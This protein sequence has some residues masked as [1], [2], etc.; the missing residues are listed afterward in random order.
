MMWPAETAGSVSYYDVAPL[1]NTIERLVD[2]DCI[3]SNRVRFSV[4]AVNVG[5]GNFTYFDNSMHNITPA[6][7]MASGALPPC[8]T[9]CVNS[10]AKSRCPARVPGAY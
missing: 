10:W 8:C 3:N 5:T 6:H 2:F 1:K 4:G 7:V 9:T